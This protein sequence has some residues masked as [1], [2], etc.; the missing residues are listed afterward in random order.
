V[1]LAKL[2]S[3]DVSGCAE[4]NRDTDVTYALDRTM[5]SSFSPTRLRSTAGCN[6]IFA[7]YKHTTIQ[8]SPCS[9]DLVTIVNDQETKEKGHT[10]LRGM[11]MDL[12][13]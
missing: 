2:E 9:R 10:F 1:C 13:C 11:G 5:K 3:Q 7:T 6:P 4:P 12:G 8:T